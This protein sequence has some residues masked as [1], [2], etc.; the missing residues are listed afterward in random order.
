MSVSYICGL[1]FVLSGVMRDFWL[2]NKLS[3]ETFLEARCGHVKLPGNRL[4]REATR[5]ECSHKS[6]GL[7]N[8]HI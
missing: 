6:A 7:D 4:L 5:A 1:I 3:M 8:N 2:L